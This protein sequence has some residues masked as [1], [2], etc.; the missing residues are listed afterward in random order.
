MYCRDGLF[1]VC[2]W[3]KI[4]FGVA[5]GVAFGVAFL[6]LQ[7]RNVEFGVAF[8]VAFCFVFF[9]FNPT[10]FQNRGRN[11]AFSCVFEY[12]NNKVHRIRG[13]LLSVKSY[14]IATYRVLGSRRVYISYSDA[15]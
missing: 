7:K 8:G 5:L 2:K 10:N 9:V 1:C 13:A 12:Q 15:K 4:R 11:T 3:A 6:P 14:K